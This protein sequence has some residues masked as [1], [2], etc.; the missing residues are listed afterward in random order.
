MMM[1]MMIMTTMTMMMIKIHC[2]DWG[3][4]LHKMDEIGLQQ[5]T[6]THSDIVRTGAI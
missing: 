3:H 1:M 5:Y 6:N 4:T 2:Y